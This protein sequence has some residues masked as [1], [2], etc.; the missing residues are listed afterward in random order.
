MYIESADLGA[1]KFPVL[2]QN[3]TL[4]C[5]GQG[6]PNPVCKL[7]KEGLVLVSDTS[8]ISYTIDR[9]GISDIGMYSCV[10]YNSA[11]EKKDTFQ[12]NSKF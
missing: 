3:L 12:L 8:P 1:N 2:D 10:C 5:I 11:G 7:E 9:M 6:D 4:H